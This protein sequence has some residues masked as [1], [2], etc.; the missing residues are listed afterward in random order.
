M[1]WL[2]RLT[3]LIVCA[4]IGIG[5]AY[6]QGQDQGTTAS[7]SAPNFKKHR[8]PELTLVVARDEPV[9]SSWHPLTETMMP[10]RFL[11]FEDG[12]AT[13]LRF[14]KDGE[15]SVVEVTD[16]PLVTPLFTNPDIRVK[17]TDTMNG[18]VTFVYRPDY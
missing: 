16:E 3:L 10:I 7:T 13:R 17:D 11:G 9:P 6:Y 1:K 4:G 5:V 14:E 18:T 8:Q 2:V 12:D 15:E